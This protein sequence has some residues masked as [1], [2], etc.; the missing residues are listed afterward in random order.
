M[1]P[2]ERAAHAKEAL[3]NPVLKEAFEQVR[4]GIIAKIETCG[5]SDVETQHECTL[6]LQLLKQVK[7]RLERHIED[8]KVEQ[9]KQEQEAWI[10]KA[11]QRLNRI[12]R[13]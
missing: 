4:T 1:T 13:A 5:L 12:G 7:G 9:K 8:A 3:A 6:M 11:R 2:I 10:E